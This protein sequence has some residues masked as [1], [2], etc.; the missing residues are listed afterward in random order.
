MPSRLL[1]KLPVKPK[2]RY[3][4]TDFSFLGQIP[5]ILVPKSR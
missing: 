3:L 4:S 5:H 2:I 1:K